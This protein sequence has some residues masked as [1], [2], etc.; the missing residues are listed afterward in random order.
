[1]SDLLGLR[2]DHY[3]LSMLSA[4]LQRGTAGRD[5]TFEVFCRRL[6]SG[7]RYGVMA[8]LGRILEAVPRFAFDGDDIAYLL[9]HRV[10][11]DQ[12]ARFLAVV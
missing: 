2:T 11:S 3:E 4:A 5:C 1:M 9:E 12:A 7:R 8:G 6:P 10:V